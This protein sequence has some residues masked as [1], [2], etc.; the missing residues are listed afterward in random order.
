MT[1]PKVGSAVRGWASVLPRTLDVVGAILLF[2]MMMLTFV[3][4]V[5]R[6]VFSRPVLGAFEITEFMLA[7]LI[8]VGIP[9]ITLRGGH[10]TVDL[11]D[12]FLSDTVKRIRNRLVYVLWAVV[13]AYLG[14][15]LWIKTIDLVDTN[16]IT[17][18][19]RW[20]VAPLG[21]IM[22]VLVFLSA[23]IALLIAITGA[24]PGQEQEEHPEKAEYT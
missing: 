22:V 20:P 1:E 11:F 14:Y 9:L 15:Q 12:H 17:Q 13:L 24:L 4:V 3:D 23:L 5:G 18:V 16:E 21:Y 10:I 2:A 7:T 6:Y 8:F 19:L